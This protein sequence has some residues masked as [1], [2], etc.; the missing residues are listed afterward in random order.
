MLVDTDVLIWYL[1]GNE[2]AYRA[3]VSESGLCISVITYMELVQGMR[4]KTELNYLRRSLRQ[5]NAKLLYISEE[6][7]AKAMFYVEQYYLSHS[8]QVADALVGATAVAHSLP[9]FTGNG[10][11]YR[12]VKDIQIKKFRP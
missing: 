1:R 4:N 12:T 2:K 8:L 5:W 7:S 6:I 9:I 11:H 10:R 3:I